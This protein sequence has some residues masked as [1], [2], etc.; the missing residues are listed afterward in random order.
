MQ[1]GMRIP[2]WLIVK[3]Q[4]A[5]LKAK[6][7]ANPET[8]RFEEMKRPLRYLKIMCLVKCLDKISG[9]YPFGF[10]AKLI[11][12]QDDMFLLQVSADL[13]TSLALQCGENRAR[14]IFDESFE[15]VFR[16]PSANLCNIIEVTE[17]KLY[18]I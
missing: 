8:Q 4:S 5:R 9:P 15:V 17:I 10:R 7:A 2:L 11:A 14:A 16:H 13:Y 12:I 3:L 6:Y 18:E 1:L